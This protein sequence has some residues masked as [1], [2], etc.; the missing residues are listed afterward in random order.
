M[1]PMTMF[2]TAAGV[3]VVGWFVYTKVTT[4]NKAQNALVLAKEAAAGTNVNMPPPPTLLIGASSSKPLAG[5]SY[6]RTR[7]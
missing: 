4:A 1:K 3:G 5:T 7:R 6:Y 2:L